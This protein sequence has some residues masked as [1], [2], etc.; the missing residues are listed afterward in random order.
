MGLGPSLPPASQAW[1]DSA[2]FVE[3]IC[4]FSTMP[5]AEIFS[6]S[7]LIETEANEDHWDDRMRS[8]HDRTR[9]VSDS[10]SLA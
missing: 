3:V 1:Q 5:E 9:P 2:L 10:N 4:I 8:L 7:S 6:K